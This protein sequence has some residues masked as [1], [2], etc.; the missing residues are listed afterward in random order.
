MSGGGAGRRQG[1]GGA[2]EDDRDAV[3]VVGGGAAGVGAALAAAE[4][5]RRVCLVLGGAG[6]SALSGG[7]VDWV[8]W[9]L[10]TGAGLGLGGLGLGDG[11]GGAEF[12]LDLYRV[13]VGGVVLATVSGILRPAAG[14]DWGLLDVKGLG[15]GTVLVPRAEHHEWD[16]VTLSRSW[17]DTEIARAG[18][19]QF[20]AADATILRFREERTLGHADIAARH[21]EPA[22]LGWLAERLR[23]ALARSGPCVAVLLPPWLGLD[24]PRAE[25]LSER[26]GLPCGEAASALASPA[27][28]RFE[29]ARDRALLRANVTV[30]RGWVQRIAHDASGWR[31]HLEGGASLDGSSIVLAAGGLVGGGLAYEPG[32]LHAN[33]EIAAAPA[34]Q[35]FRVTIAS[36]G[37][38]GAYGRPLELP[39]SLFG[40]P[41]E[42]LA[43]PFAPDPVMERAGLLVDEHQ[44]VQGAPDG[45]YACG[46]LVADAPRTWLE[47]WRSGVRAGRYERK[48]GTER[49]VRPRT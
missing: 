31:A 20:Q 18:G 3:I 47:A 35:A 6:A 13:P 1:V 39:G 33:A 22:R 11:A 27:G 41:P 7:A 17:G 43:W 24:A 29:R 14:A 48:G 40:A 4:V 19:L 12:V 28:R 45:L 9:E 5:G 46:D 32:D 8:D 23:E 16:A 37:T 25:A 38:V 49:A 10:G 2:G 21:D 44:R 30:V 36:P 42:S 34:R 15:R 26:V